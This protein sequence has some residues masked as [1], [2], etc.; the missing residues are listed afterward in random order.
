[1]IGGF[2]GEPT[3]NTFAA[4][5]PYLYRVYTEHQGLLANRQA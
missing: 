3:Q 2:G 4:G 5:G 1:M